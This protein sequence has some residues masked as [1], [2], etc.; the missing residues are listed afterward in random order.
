M[1]YVGSDRLGASATWA[2]VI[3]LPQPQLLRL[4]VHRG[5]SEQIRKIAMV[6]LYKEHAL[7]LA[8]TSFAT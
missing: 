1:A 7:T 8:I 4:H 2:W 6:P 3:L 5:V